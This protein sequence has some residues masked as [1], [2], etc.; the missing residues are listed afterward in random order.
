M[1]MVNTSDSSTQQVNRNNNNITSTQGAGE[2]NVCSRGCGYQDEEYS[3]K[4]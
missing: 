4:G 3:T 1:L 2:R